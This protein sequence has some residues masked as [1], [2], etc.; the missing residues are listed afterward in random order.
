MKRFF[1]IALTIFAC[2]ASEAQSSYGY[3]YPKRE[4][5]AVWLT[6]IGGLDWPH[7]YAQSDASVKK[8]QQELKTLL[9]T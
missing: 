5:R 6:T 8:Q 3:I 1:A 4:V 2:L 9:D 7:T